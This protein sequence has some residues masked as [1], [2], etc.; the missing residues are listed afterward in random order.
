MV[1]RLNHYRE[2]RFSIQLL[3]YI[4]NYLYAAFQQKETVT[5]ID[6]R[7]ERIGTVSLTL[8]K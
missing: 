3:Y 4:I 7:L 6:A 8:I 2:A 1:S 5:R